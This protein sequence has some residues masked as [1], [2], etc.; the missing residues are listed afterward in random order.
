MD[1]STSL[2]RVYRLPHVKV[3]VRV[4][5]ICRDATLKLELHASV[6]RE[7]HGRDDGPCVGEIDRTE[8]GFGA[9]LCVEVISESP[10]VVVE[11]IVDQPINLDVIGDVI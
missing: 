4:Y 2:T 9:F 11:E 7:R 1:F 10:V 6:G 5:F 8:R 3:P